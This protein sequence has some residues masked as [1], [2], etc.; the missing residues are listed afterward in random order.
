MSNSP[1][2]RS[3]SSGRRRT[4]ALRT[5]HIFAQ[6]PTATLLFGPS[7]CAVSVQGSDGGDGDG[8]GVDDDDDGS[9]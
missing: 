7:V 3:L 8:G 2:A 9:P 5:Q 4:C 1:R 6:R